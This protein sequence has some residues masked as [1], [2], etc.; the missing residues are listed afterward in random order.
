M[1]ETLVLKIKVL[2]RQ[3]EGLRGKILRLEEQITHLQKKKRNL[4][5]EVTKLESLETKRS[6]SVSTSSEDDQPPLDP[7][8]PAA[9]AYSD[10]LDQKI[11]E[12]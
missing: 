2:D 9:Q 4:Q 12:L 11:Q 7:E 1:K 8:D 6:K 10:W 5:L 3:E